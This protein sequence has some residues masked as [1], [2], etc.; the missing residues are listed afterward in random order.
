MAVTLPK[1]RF[2]IADRSPSDNLLLGDLEFSDD[3]LSAGLEHAAREFNSIPPVAWRVRPGALPDDTNLFYEAAAE[4]LYKQRLHK[5]LRNQL[6]YQA[7]NVQ[8]DDIGPKIE[9][10][11][12]LIQMV[13]GW[14]ATA[15]SIKLKNDTA[16]YF[17]R[18]A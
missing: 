11:K 12:Q 4:M 18:L 1:L 16:R 5:L 8:V 3:E 17:N 6:K 13:S 9:G 2:W 10:L 14:R 7:G 15:Q